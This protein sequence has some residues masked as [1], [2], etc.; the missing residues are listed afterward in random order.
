MSSTSCSHIK[1]NGVRCGSPSLRGEQFCYFH[2]RMLRSVRTPPH[3]RLHPIANLEDENAIQASLMEVMNAVLRNTID[4]RRAELLIRT[5]NA[6]IRNIHRANFRIA[7]DEM[8]REVPE[9][10]VPREVTEHEKR[11]AAARKKAAEEAAKAAADPNAPKPPAAP[12]IFPESARVFAAYDRLEAHLHDSQQRKKPMSASETQFRS[13][14]H[15]F[16]YG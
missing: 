1:V 13:D 6:A 15:T 7:K 10:P 2:Q 8:V 5:L 3:A 9:Y 4:I 14:L 11:L 12:A 16:L